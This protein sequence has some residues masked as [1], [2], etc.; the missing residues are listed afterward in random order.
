MYLSLKKKAKDSAVDK[1]AGREEASAD[2]VAQKGV[3]SAP[4][5]DGE[6][7]GV[8]KNYRGLNTTCGDER[9]LRRLDGRHTKSNVSSSLPTWIGPGHYA[10]GLK[11]KDTERPDSSFQVSFRNTGRV[12]KNSEYHKAA[13]LEKLSKSTSFSVDDV[14]DMRMSFSASSTCSRGH[15]DDA[16]MSSDLMCT[17][18]WSTSSAQSTI[19]RPASQSG[20]HSPQR[21][22]I[23]SPKKS[24]GPYESVISEFIGLSYNKSE[25]MQSIGLDDSVNF[26]TLDPLV[27]KAADADKRKYKHS[28]FAMGGLDMQDEIPVL[29]LDEDGEVVVE[30]PKSPSPPLLRKMSS[31]KKSH[32][33]SKH[34]SVDDRP[35]SKAQ[36]VL[37][38]VRHDL[39][40]TRKSKLRNQSVTLTDSLSCIIDDWQT[41]ENVESSGIYGKSKSKLRQKRAGGGQFAPDVVN[42]DQLLMDDTGMSFEEA[43]VLVEEY[44]ESIDI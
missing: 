24:V 10:S 16:D 14:D 1:T 26:N 17:N 40:H 29:N 21:V 6:V 42:L 5:L 27:L 7:I 20:R 2:E 11:A 37:S 38:R 35:K 39:T 44:S 3:M 4:S 19:G 12:I 9:T 36:R 13:R 41:S 28:D 8:V 34:K 43:K 25:S 22:F 32:P 23:H 33:N 31:A 18:P 30:P 15:D